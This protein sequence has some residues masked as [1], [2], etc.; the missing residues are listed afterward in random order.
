MLKDMVE[1]FVIGA[2]AWRVD[3]IWNILFRN[4]NWGHSGGPVVYGAMSAID[5]ALL[6]IKGRMLGVPVYDLLGG[7]VRDSI[8]VYANGWYFQDRNVR[9]FGH[10]KEYAEAALR[11]VGTGFN[12]LKLEPFLARPDGTTC[13]HERALSREMADLGYARVAAVREAVGPDVDIL[14]DALGNLGAASA[15]QIGRRL[16]EL[17]PF[18][19]EEPVDSTNVECMLK[20]AQN[21][22]IPI[23]AGER[24]YTRYGFRQY[25]EKQAVDVLQPDIG[26]AGG[27]SE[28]KKIATYGE[29]YGLHV[30]PHNCGGPISTAA[31]VQL[32]ACITNFIIQEWF[33]NRDSTFYDL[34]EDALEQHVTNSQFAIP[35]EPGLGI[36]LNERA[37]ARYPCIHVP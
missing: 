29:V 18:L 35:N 7:K 11:T 19:Y 27:I 21:V 33:P 32:D 23:A 8:R 14:V 4:T 2:D 24:L 17:D 1:A 5:E 25:I 30:Q 6:D 34:V 28:A 13:M 31:S 3:H 20:V 37:I 36:N 15:I 16:A 10:P 9:Y 26:L 12:A 22:P